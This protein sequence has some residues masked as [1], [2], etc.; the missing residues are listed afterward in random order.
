[1]HAPQAENC[2]QNRLMEA[3][4]EEAEAVQAF[5]P[6]LYARCEIE[7]ES[8]DSFVIACRYALFWSSEF[9]L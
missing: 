4:V 9:L 1:M 2:S 6:T 7:R 8:C 3:I 5:L